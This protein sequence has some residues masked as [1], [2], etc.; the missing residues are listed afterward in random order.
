MD[1]HK[2]ADLNSISRPLPF[3]PWLKRSIAHSGKH[4]S[5]ND[6][7]HC[8]GLHTVCVEAKCPNRSE[9]YSKGIATFLIMGNICTRNCSFC[10]VSSGKPGPL[11]PQEPIRLVHAAQKLQLK[12]LVITSVTRDDLSDGGAGF[13]AGLVQLLRTELSRSFN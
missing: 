6:H 1:S 4:K 13:Y 3:P 11:D 2:N 12:H 5:I 7:V 9:C 10:G 8:S